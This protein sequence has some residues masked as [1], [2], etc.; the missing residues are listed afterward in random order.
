MRFVPAAALL[1]LI[2]PG[3][4]A[5]TSAGFRVVSSAFVYEHAPFP[6]AHASTIVETAD[7]LVAAWFGGTAEKNPDVGIWVSRRPGESWTP[8]V[9]VATGVQ[10]DGTRH[11]TWNPVLFEP[12]GGPLLLFYKVG[13]SPRR[14][15][16]M[17]T[18]S[19]DR[20]RTWAPPARL[21]DGQLGPIRAKPVAL[22]DGTFLAGSSTE[23]AGWVVHM[24]TFRAP[25]PASQD[26]GRWV[27]WLSTAAA[28]TRSAPLNRR[29]EFGAI[30]PTILVHGP[31]T[32]QI[33][34]RSTQKV[35]TE[36]WSEDGGAT[37]SPMRRTPLPNPSAG[38]DS[39]RLG[40][41]RF[42]LVYNPS[43]G[44]RR[45][46]S[47]AA[48]PDGRAWTRV[49]DVDQGPGEYSYPAMIATRDGRVHVTY[50]WRRERIKHVTITPTPN[51]QVPSPRPHE[52]RE[53]ATSWRLGV[54]SWRLV[55][56]LLQLAGV[57]A[58][59]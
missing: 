10:E 17:V 12:P 43:A 29:Q 25:Q 7:G 52:G 32:L 36:S 33:L 9:E 50:T 26:A 28:W 5:A 21:P 56:A 49:L 48:S 41:G 19:A 51:A 54:G 31:K 55:E 38:I 16:G 35:I 20:G 22:A 13:P 39:V 30:Q 27:E 11:P 45:T 57:G 1:L 23:H 6:S 15:W 53:M 34:C 2:T 40:D 3:L 47:I 18:A 58:P 37:W 8:P 24:E 42:L 4:P 44:N 46:L 59:S 14:W